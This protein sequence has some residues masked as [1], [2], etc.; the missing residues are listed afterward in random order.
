MRVRSRYQSCKGLN[1]SEV[2]RSVVKKV[3]ISRQVATTHAA[4]AREVADGQARLPAVE[5]QS[6]R[7]AEQQL[8]D[9]DGLGMLTWISQAHEQT[10][11]VVGQRVDAGHEV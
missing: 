11:L 2:R 9:G 6:R 3:A 7:C 1:C 5:G 8:A 10:L 4:S